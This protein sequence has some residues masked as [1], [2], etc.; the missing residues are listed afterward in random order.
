VGGA[1]DD[2]S[3]SL[4]STS[5]STSG[6]AGAA[7]APRN[8]G[9]ANRLSGG[10]EPALAGAAMP[11]LTDPAATGFATPHSKTIDVP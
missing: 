10:S 3:A 6:D 11:E 9:F 2:H 1:V 7:R 8:A 4:A 5:A